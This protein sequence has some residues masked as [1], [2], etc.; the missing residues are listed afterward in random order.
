MFKYFERLFHNYCLIIVLHSTDNQYTNSYCNNSDLT[1]T[2][3]GKKG[4][5][6]LY[7][8]KTLLVPIYH[9]IS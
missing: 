2:V 5:D 1:L 4:K 9:D 3:V 8:N 7:N 6:Q